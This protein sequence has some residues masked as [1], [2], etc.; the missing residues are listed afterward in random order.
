VPIEITGKF[1]K[2]D[3]RHNFADISKIKKLLGFEPKIDFSK[4][5]KKYVD[6]VKTQANPENN[7]EQ[8]LAEMSAKGLYK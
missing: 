4:G 8:S 6:W 5:M 3:I 2:G 1:R 7:F